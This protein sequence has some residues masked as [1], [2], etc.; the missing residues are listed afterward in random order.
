MK[1]QSLLLTMLFASSIAWAD[2][3]PDHDTSNIQQQNLSRRAYTAPVTAKADKFEGDVDVAK[4]AEAEKRFK[5]LQLHMLGKRPY[6][7]KN[8][9]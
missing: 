5:T 7:E 8:T 4:E 9:D 1:A 2:H 6:A 3:T